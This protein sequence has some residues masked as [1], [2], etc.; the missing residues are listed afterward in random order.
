MN[1]VALKKKLALLKKK[2]EQMLKESKPKRRRGRPPGS[3]NKASTNN[4]SAAHSRRR[5]KFSLEM[6]PVYKPVAGLSRVIRKTD[7]GF[8]RQWAVSSGTEL[9]GYFNDYDDAAKAAKEQK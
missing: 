5:A 6:K 9:V 2:K 3:K 4:N 8:I 7:T 1:I